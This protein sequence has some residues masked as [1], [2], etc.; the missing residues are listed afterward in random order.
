MHL[1]TLSSEAFLLLCFLICAPKI[2]SQALPPNI[3][4]FNARPRAVTEASSTEKNI[5]DSSTSSSDEPSLFDDDNEDEEK[6]NEKPSLSS[7]PSL[8][9][10]ADTIFAV[11]GKQN[12]DIE[13]LDTLKRSSPCTIERRQHRFRCSATADSATISVDGR[14]RGTPTKLDVTVK[15]FLR[16]KIRRGRVVKVRMEDATVDVKKMPDEM[17]MWR[18]RGLRR[19]QRELKRRYIRLSIAIRR[20]SR[21]ML[22]KEV[23]L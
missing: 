11:L 10:L 7:S 19:I 23:K 9:K 12:L 17:S 2:Y 8:D 16:G 4:D 20:I 14:G 18:P 1:S 13:K 21:R 22:P 5:I 15:V 3:D 6:K